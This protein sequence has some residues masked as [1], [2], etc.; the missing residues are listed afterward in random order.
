MWQ[1]AQRS[2]MRVLAARRELGP[3]PRRSG[4]SRSSAPRST[5]RFTHAAV[6]PLVAEKTIC[7]VSSSHGRPAGQV[8][9]PA[10]EID[11]RLAVA[12]DAQAA[13]TSPWCSK[14]SRE[15]VAHRLEPRSDPAVDGQSVLRTPCGMMSC[16]R[17]PSPAPGL[18][19]STR[20]ASRRMPGAPLG[21]CR[22]S[23]GQDPSFA[24]LPLGRSFC[25]RKSPSGYPLERNMPA[26][27]IPAGTSVLR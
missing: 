9:E 17:A 12:V 25:S 1:S 16:H 21:T 13:P 26:G 14:F 23:E 20:R 7:A 10:P 22:V 24:N 27:R 2:G 6:T 18:R 8:G 19:S 5:S 4:A 3:V 11:H 15:G